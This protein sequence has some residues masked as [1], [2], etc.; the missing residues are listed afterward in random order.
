V[1]LQAITD[2]VQKTLQG[3]GKNWQCHLLRVIWLRRHSWSFASLSFGCAVI[4][5]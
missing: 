3:N 5:I 2:E 4:R 1:F